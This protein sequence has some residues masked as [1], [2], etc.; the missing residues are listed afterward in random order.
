MMIEYTTCLSHPSAR[1]RAQGRS[2]AVRQELKIQAIFLLA[3]PL[4]K[5]RFFGLCSAS[6]PPSS[7]L[8]SFPIIHWK[9]KGSTG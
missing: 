1:V 5:T 3:L 4:C 8:P 6:V 9:N 7:L 2:T